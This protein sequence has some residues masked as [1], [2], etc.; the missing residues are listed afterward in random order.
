MGRLV[1]GSVRRAG[2][3]CASTCAWSPSSPGGA[4]AT[5]ALGAESADEG[6]LFRMVARSGRAAARELGA[7][8]PRTEHAGARRPPRWRRRRPTARGASGCC[9]GDAVGAAPA[10]ER[11][12]AADPG[13]AAALEGS[14]EAYQTLGYHDK[15]RGGGGARRRGRRAGRDAP[16]CRV[17]ARLALLRGDPAEAE[18][19]YAELARRYPN[20]TEALLDLAAAQAAQGAAPRRWRRLQRATELDRR[21]PRAWFLLGQN[22]ILAGDARQAVTDP[23]VRA[24][25]LRPSWATS[26]GRP[27]C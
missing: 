5:R 15:A 25:A 9:V 23:L 18:K 27:T 3:A 16:A 8:P 17:R 4:L 2:A 10:F 1:T 22:M 11:A 26:R 20:D 6:G 13:F 21:D 12:V 24:L 19:R 14:S 7:G